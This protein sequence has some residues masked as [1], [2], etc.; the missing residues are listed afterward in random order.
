MQ[1]HGPVSP[2]D[3]LPH[4][5][6]QDTFGKAAVQQDGLDAFRGSDQII[7]GRMH[8]QFPCIENDHLV[9]KPSDIVD[10]MR[11]KN[12]TLGV[13]ASPFDKNLDQFVPRKRVES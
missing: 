13:F 9:R 2:I 12:D 7:D 10:L 3:A 11:R 6:L 8:K 1:G 5:L 4:G